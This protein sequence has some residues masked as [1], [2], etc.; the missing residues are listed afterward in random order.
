M[1]AYTRF[2]TSNTSVAPATC[3]NGQKDTGETVQNCALDFVDVGPTCGNGLCETERQDLGESLIN[4]P[5]D[6][7]PPGDLALSCIKLFDVNPPVI[8]PGNNNGGP[9]KPTATTPA[10]QPTLT[11][12][13]CVP[14]APDHSGIG[15][16]KC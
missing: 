6:C 1:A 2:L 14:V 8:P 13:P 12:I 9:K 16:K 10:G 11:P 5:A 15:G 7:M 3:G 4:C